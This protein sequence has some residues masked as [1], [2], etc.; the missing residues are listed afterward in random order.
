MLHWIVQLFLVVLL[1]SVLGFVLFFVLMLINNVRTNSKINYTQNTLFNMST[2]AFCVD[3]SPLK[4]K[5][6]IITGSTNGIGEQAASDMY[7]MG[8]HVIVASRTLSKC[9]DTVARIKAKHP[10]SAG[11]VE[12]MQ[13]DTSDFDNVRAFAKKFNKSFPKL[14]FIVNNAGIH[15]LSS[16]GSPLI[17]PEV[18]T[19]SKQGFDLAFATNYMGHWLLTDL[20]LPKLTSTGEA[21]NC[22]TR[23]VN[24]SSAYHLGVSGVMLQPVDFKQGSSVAATMPHAARTDDFTRLHRRRS[25][26]NNKLAQVLHTH[27]LDRRLKA[28]GNDNV[29]VVSVCPGWVGGTGIVAET[30]AEK[31]IKSF[32]FELAASTMAHIGM[33]TAVLYVLFVMFIL[34]Y[35]SVS[36]LCCVDT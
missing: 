6:A 24:I 10:R 5:V 26:S 35:T 22:P 36:L 18:K 1:T 2:Q 11:K 14:H 9:H 19:I 15:Y 3:R 16:P 8:A 34:Y 13:L 21:E 7:N 12:A 30:L 25:Y 32:G 31:V 27:E 23:V 28:Q 33:F 4:G 17:N 29:Q 20:L